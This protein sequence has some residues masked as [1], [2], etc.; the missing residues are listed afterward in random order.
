MSAQWPSY[1]E[2]QQP[3][4]ALQPGSPSP[5][6]AWPTSSSAGLAAS[7]LL[8]IASQ[9]MTA[10]S[11]AQCHHRPWAPCCTRCICRTSKISL[12]VQEAA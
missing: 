4:T 7:L 8:T 10:H 1:M 5:A 12:C 3:L 2:L 11:L 6:T 9:L